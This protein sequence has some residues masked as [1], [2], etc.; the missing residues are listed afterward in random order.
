[1]EMKLQLGVFLLHIQV[2]LAVW[3]HVTVI[4]GQTLHLTCPLTDAHKTIV[5]W[6]NPDNNLMFFNRKEGEDGKSFLRDKRYSIDKLSH[7]EFS[8]SVSNVTFSDGGT[9]TCTHYDH[10]TIEKKVEVTVLGHPRISTARHEGETVIKCSAEGNHHPP[11]IYW[12]FDN[13]PEFRGAANY[14]R[15]NKK[16][17]TLGMLHVIPVRNRVTVKCLV[18]H[19]ALHSQPLMNFVKIGAD[20]KKPLPTT[21]ASSPTVQP[22]GTTTRWFI[23]GRTLVYYTTRDVNGPSSDGSTVTSDQWVSSSDPKTVTAPTRLPLSPVTFTEPLLSTS[24]SL[25]VD[26][27]RSSVVPDSTVMSNDTTSEETNTTGGASIS[28]TPDDFNNSTNRTLTDGFGSNKQMATKGN[29]TLLVLL[30]TCLIFGLLVVVI[31]FTIKLRRAHLAW[32][33]ENE[34]SDPSEESSKSKASQ[35]EKNS[36]GQRRRGILNTAFTQYIVEEPT[37]ITSVINT[38]AMAPR[39]SSTREQTSPPQTQAQPP[40]NIKETSL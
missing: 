19:P 8:I 22:L 5:E 4:K 39:E 23:Y 37:V 10:H 14:H 9:Y 25:T 12:K 24:D 31:F 35:E 13:G 18:R 20:T 16:F 7:S 40:A 6:K 26:G 11:K 21:T 32:K 2:S 28:A 29:S 1:M 27:S 17:V 30:V 15:E 36:Q 38:S 34:E 33:R 3:Q